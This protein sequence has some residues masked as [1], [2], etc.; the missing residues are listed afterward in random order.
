MITI[1]LFG[2]ASGAKMQNMAYTGP[3]SDRKTYDGALKEQVSVGSISGGQET[4]PMWV[5]DISD[6]AF[7]GAH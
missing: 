4:N 7:L 6:E 2:C 3:G 5:P 1:F